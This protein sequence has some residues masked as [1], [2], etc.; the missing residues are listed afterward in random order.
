MTKR[1]KAKS[2]LELMLHFEA[3]FERLLKDN[4][5]SPWTEVAEV[6]A[7]ETVDWIEGYDE[8]VTAA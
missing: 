7:K 6:L 8:L 4:D 3:L 2:R 1:I 5:C